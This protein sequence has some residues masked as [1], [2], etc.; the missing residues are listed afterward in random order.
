MYCAEEVLRIPPISL[1]PPYGMASNPGADTA[2]TDS[3]WLAACPTTLRTNDC[4]DRLRFRELV[5]PELP[6]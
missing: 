1:I 5:S 4:K 2:G 3:G 6:S